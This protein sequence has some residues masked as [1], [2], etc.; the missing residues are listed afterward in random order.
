ME[1]GPF[2]CFFSCSV[3]FLW[4]KSKKLYG[5]HLEGE[6][7]EFFLT[8]DKTLIYIEDS[9]GKSRICYVMLGE[10]IPEVHVLENGKSFKKG[11]MVVVIFTGNGI[12][13]LVKVLSVTKII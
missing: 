3:S 11:F 2:F 6:R 8:L 13:Q 7:S 12:V 5:K 9:T 10:Q 4:V 1:K